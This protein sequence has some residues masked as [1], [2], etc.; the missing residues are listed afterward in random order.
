MAGLLKDEA[1]NK[2]RREREKKR[3]AKAKVKKQAKR[4]Q[5]RRK[6]EGRKKS[7][8]AESDSSDDSSSSGDSSDTTSS[9]LSSDSSSDS[10]SASNRHKKSKSRDGGGRDGTS[11][12]KRWRPEDLE[13]RWING[14]KHF[15]ICKGTWHQPALLTMHVLWQPP[16]GVPECRVRM[17]LRRR[18][19]PPCPKGGGGHWQTMLQANV[20]SRRY[21]SGMH[22]GPCWR[23][24]SVRLAAHTRLQYGG[25]WRMAPERRT[26]GRY[27]GSCVTAGSMASSR[28][29]KRSRDPCYRWPE[30]ANVRRRLRPYCPDYA[31]RKRCPSFQRSWCVRTSCS[32][33]HWKGSGYRETR[34]TS[35]GPRETSFAGSQRIRGS[36]RSL[37]ALE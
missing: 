8:M 25:S 11:K 29:A 35:N 15:R 32:L 28:H 14:C 4:E 18:S 24:Q 10:Y 19:R 23:R 27:T 12:P 20:T 7:K 6:H 22:W 37:S 30:M 21:G 9:D 3:K 33:S 2:G 26:L 16:L 34:G 5:K 31:Q 1:K 36:G 17:P 13:F